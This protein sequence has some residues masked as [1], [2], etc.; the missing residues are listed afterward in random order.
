ML[1]ISNVVAGS[2]GAM[3]ALALPL[4][5]PV[6]EYEVRWFAA[7]CCVVE[8]D[9]ECRVIVAESLIGTYEVHHRDRGPRNILAVTLAKAPG[10]HLGQ[11]AA[12]FGISDEYLRIQEVWSAESWHGSGIP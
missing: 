3:D 7:N 8:R 5:L 4:G 9:G 12:A 6:T 10:M 11:L 2:K 1:G